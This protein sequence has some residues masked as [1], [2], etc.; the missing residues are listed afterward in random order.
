[1]RALLI[2]VLTPTL[3]LAGCATMANGSHAGHHLAGAPASANG[4]HEN[5]PMMSGTS[6]QHT[7]QSGMTQ[8]GE[9]GMTPGGQGSMMQGGQNGM[10]QGG[11]QA[12]GPQSGAPQG[13]AQTGSGMMSGAH[14][15]GAM[16]NCPMSQSATPAQTAPHPAQT[17]PADLHNHQ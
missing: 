3:L 11:N 1:M 6:D 4:M 10:M 9:G 12:G 5:C 7:V 16:L 8:G 13:G 2:S 17:P 15:Q 14:Q